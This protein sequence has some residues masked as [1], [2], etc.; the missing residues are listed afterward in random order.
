[1]RFKHIEGQLARWLEELA[2]YD[3]EI[4]HRLTPGR[5]HINADGLSRLHDEIPECD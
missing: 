2:Q 1:M 3:M 5:K 4:I